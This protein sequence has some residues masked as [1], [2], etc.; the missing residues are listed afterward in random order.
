MTKMKPKDNDR[1]VET[2]VTGKWPSMSSPD[3]SIW[4]KF[5]IEN[6]ARLM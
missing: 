2:L 3:Q 6:S 4:L 1:I 5:N